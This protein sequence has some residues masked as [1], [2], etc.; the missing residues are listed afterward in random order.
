MDIFWWAIG[1]AVVCFVLVK[2]LPKGQPAGGASATITTRERDPTSEWVDLDLMPASPPQG[3]KWT[4][5]AGAQEVAGTQ[6]CRNANLEFIDALTKG[7]NLD[8]PYGLVLTRDPDNPVDT[9]AIKV[10]GWCN[11]IDRDRW[12]IGYVDA[13]TAGAI[14]QHPS[15]MPL[16][17]SLK[18]IRSGRNMLFVKYDLLV[19][20][21]AERR[22]NGW[23]SPDEQSRSE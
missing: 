12:L 18:R 7:D 2:V 9:N 22:K 4:K 6:H 17:A 14:G 15:E 23:L 3:V 20:S 8:R 10:W 13:V 11:D 16:A 19:P 5:F 1:A 21:K